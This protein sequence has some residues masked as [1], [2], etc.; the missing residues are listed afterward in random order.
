MSWLDDVFGSSLSQG[1]G[2]P[3]GESDD[4]QRMREHNEALAQLRADRKLTQ[5]LARQAADRASAPFNSSAPTRKHQVSLGVTA[6]PD[7]MGNYVRDNPFGS[8]TSPAP[9]PNV[10][11]LATPQPSSP[12][13][14]SYPSPAPGNEDRAGSPWVS[15]YM[16]S[17]PF[18]S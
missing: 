9:N 10:Q 16:R 15:D 3:L 2:D 8:A 13:P 14:S 7:W 11:G 18:P 6:A 17:N 4:D 12:F 1:P 5:L